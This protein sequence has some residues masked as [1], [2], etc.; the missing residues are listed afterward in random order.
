[1]LKS[2]TSATQAA[3]ARWVIPA[4]RSKNGRAHLVPL[5]DL[6][7]QTITAAL[8]LIGKDDVYLFPSP[9][10]SGAPITAHALAVAMAR[11]A[12]KPESKV[13]KTWQAEPPTPHDLR[14][15]VATQISELGVA[16]EDV[17]AVLNHVRG[18]VTGRHYD[19]YQREREKRRALDLWAM[20]LS[21][22]VEKRASTAVVSIA[23]ARRYERL[24]SDVE[25]LASRIC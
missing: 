3:R 14:R 2:R 6:A 20:T 19:L 11:F 12:A 24:A 15:T 8:E 5:S 13:P 21:D 16:K 1:M 4:E 7:R 17:A 10:V 9:S 18:D 23:K 25:S 22:V